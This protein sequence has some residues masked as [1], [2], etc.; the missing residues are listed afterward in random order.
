MFSR[1]DM[2]N[3]GDV[4]VSDEWVQE[5]DCTDENYG[6]VEDEEEAE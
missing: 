2:D 4:V 1:C 6:F 3:D 5:I